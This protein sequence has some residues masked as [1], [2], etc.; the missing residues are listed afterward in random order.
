MR[1]EQIL[2]NQ[3]IVDSH[4]QTATNQDWNQRDENVRQYLH[5]T[6]EPVGVVSH[7]IFELLCG[8][9]DVFGGCVIEF[10][11]NM[12]HIAWPDDDLEHTTRFKRAFQIWIIIQTLAIHILGV[13]EHEA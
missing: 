9:S 12:I 13:F 7:N 2:R 5:S 6:A 4:E 3:H 8:H 10:F 11:E 1:T